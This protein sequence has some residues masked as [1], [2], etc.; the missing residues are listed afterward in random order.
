MAEFQPADPGFAERVRNSFARQGLMAHLG[1]VMT[2]V[3]PGV[4]EIEMPFTDALTQQ[5]GF[6]HAGGLAAIVDTAG[7]FAAASLF[8]PDDGVLT[9]E[10]K[11]N[12]LSPADGDLLVARGEVIRPGR[13]LTVTK[14]EV[15][16][17][18]NDQTKLCALMQQTLMRIVGK[19]GIVG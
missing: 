8:A 2:T 12:L 15:F 16:I 5:H 1:A 17:R 4:V 14:G 7:G 6:Y 10:F 11:L 3:E 13:T 18:K 9:V 19:S